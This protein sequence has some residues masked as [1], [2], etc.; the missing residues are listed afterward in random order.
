MVRG[1]WG[2]QFDA[3]IDVKLGDA[4]ADSYKYEPMTSLL[5][6]WKT[7][8]KNK[9]NKNCHEQQKK[10]AVCSLS[11]RN[12]RYGSLGRTLAIESIHGIE[13]GINPFASTRVGKRSN[14][15][16]R[17]KVLLTNDP[18]SSAPHYPVGKGSGL[19]SGIG[20]RVGRLNCLPD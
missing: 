8:K 3:I 1:L 4:D 11:R 19:G 16:C 2:R 10:I 12:A 17:C 9:H 18:R 20:N 13:N 15:N 5:A 6:R 7:I 14:C